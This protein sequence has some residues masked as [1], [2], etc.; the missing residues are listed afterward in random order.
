[1]RCLRIVVALAAAFGGIALADTIP[2]SSDATWD[3][4][5]NDPAVPPA[6]LLGKAEL[7]CLNAGAP[8]PCPSG[9][10]LYGKAVP[11]WTA[12]LTTIPGAAWIWAPG[13]TGATAPADMA[14]FFFAKTITLPGVPSGGTI[15]VAADD[16]AEV[17]INGHAA[18]TVGSITD[19]AAAA[20]AA[21][22]L[23]TFDIGPFL[24][25]G[26]NLVVVRGQNGP[27]SFAGCAGACTY[28]QN[29]AGVVFGGALTVGP[30]NLPPD[31][32]RA[33]ATPD[34]LWPPDHKFVGVQVAGVT[35][36]DGDPVTIT[37]TAVAQDEPTTNATG[38]IPGQQGDGDG[39]SC[40][41]AAGIGTATALLR[42]ERDGNGD[43]RVYH[44]AFVA[45]DGR[46]GRCTGDV[47]VCVP[48]DQGH[49]AGCVD[50]GPLFP[51][52]GPC[53][54]CAAP[55]GCDDGNPCTVDTCTPSGCVHEPVGGP[56]AVTCPFGD[57]GMSPPACG[58]VAVP[59][60]IGARVD[61]ALGLIARG[62]A[63]RY[64]RKAIRQLGRAAQLVGMA[65][66]HGL[67]RP[68]A[69]DLALRIRD[70]RTGAA[71]WLHRLRRQRGAS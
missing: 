63:P 18:G 51:A 25:P 41:T 68:C 3:V 34:S 6:V 50:E 67:Y 28:A 10:V 31:C 55:A 47:A 40:P 45:D 70:A 16:L 26:D 69:D 57:G 7:V 21:S 36:P 15:A 56:A 17:L 71:H 12:N 42:A 43:G 33:I 35:D 19:G 27:A 54:P 53:G 5:Q 8:V 29:P 20:Q 39:G 1:M 4:F 38:A 48:H 65:R 46:G 62:Q 58:G 22:T 37:I 23:T 52:T 60:S 44:I 14:Q 11:G 32:Q 2:F 64:V 49:G 59:A 30:P 9:A 24:V 61:L 13:V 66:R